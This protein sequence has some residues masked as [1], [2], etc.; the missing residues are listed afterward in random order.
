MVEIDNQ[1]NAVP[2][3]AESFEAEPDASTWVFNLR[4]GSEFHNGKSV[5]AD[6]V[7]F[8]IKRHQDEKLASQIRTIVAPIKEFKKAGRQ[9]GT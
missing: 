1:G 3:L 6:D 7:I 9:S 8:S 4:K 5:D 2:D